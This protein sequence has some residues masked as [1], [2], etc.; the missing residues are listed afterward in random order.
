MTEDKTFN[1]TVQS[2]LPF[3]VGA[4]LAGV[5]IL[6]YLTPIM[7]QLAMERVEARIEVRLTDIKI[8]TDIAK[9]DAKIA[10]E[11]ALS[12]L[13]KVEEKLK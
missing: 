11:D 1:K 7:I 3:L 4:G 2:V 13:S 9:Q 10:K 5:L 12:A 8:K 6:G